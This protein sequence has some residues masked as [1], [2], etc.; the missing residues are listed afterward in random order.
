MAKELYQGETWTPPIAI[1]QSG[2]AFDCTLYTVKMYIKG[3]MSETAAAEVIID[4][5][6][7]D[8]SSGT[9]TFS[10]THAVSKTLSLGRHFYETKIYTTADNALVKI[11][12]Q[13]VLTIKESLEKD[14]AE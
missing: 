3:S 8:Q 1:T 6:W 5:D 4:I 10:L 9:G 7:T 2:A 14:I 13:D 12:E 11:L